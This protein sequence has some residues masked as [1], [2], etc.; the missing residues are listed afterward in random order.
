VV[1]GPR[2]SGLSARNIS[3]TF[4][5]DSPRHAIP[6]AICLPVTKY[7]FVLC[8]NS[9]YPTPCNTTTFH[10]QLLRNNVFVA[11]K[12]TSLGVVWR[13]VRQQNSTFQGV[14]GL[15]SADSKQLFYYIRLPPKEYLRFFCY[16]TQHWLLIGYRRCGKIMGS[17]LKALAL[18]KKGQ[19]VDVLLFC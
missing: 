12:H 5:Q 18:Q 15:N 13:L 1:W 2:S 19:Q 17:I 4:H 14:T 7:I 16:V 3:L 11:V 9:H 10:F 6:H 8:Y